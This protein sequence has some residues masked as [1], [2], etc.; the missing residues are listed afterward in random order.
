MIEKLTYIVI[1]KEIMISAEVKKENVEIAKQ[2]IVDIIKESFFCNF[3]DD[4]RCVP[5][6]DGSFQSLEFY[7]SYKEENDT[8]QKIKDIFFQKGGLSIENSE[9]FSRRSPSDDMFG[10]SSSDLD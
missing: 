7:F 8:F 1:C 4:Y 6:N 5:I 10:R 9:D 2:K 3:C